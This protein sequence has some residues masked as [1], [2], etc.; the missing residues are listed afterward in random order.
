MGKADLGQPA[1][2]WANTQY[3]IARS[4]RN[5]FIN[6]KMILFQ[7]KA[8]QIRD[9]LY[10]GSSI[11]TSDIDSLVFSGKMIKA[12]ILVSHNNIHETGLNDFHEDYMSSAWN[13]I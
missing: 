3:G 5:L 12:P 1:S 13:K 10:L 8:R 2:R 7:L 6:L 9:G 11:L 4:Y